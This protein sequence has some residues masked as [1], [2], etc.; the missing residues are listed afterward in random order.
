MATL[1]I[2]H[3][4]KERPRAEWLRAALQERG[5]ESLFL[6][7]HPDD[8][9]PAGSKWEQQ[10]WRQLRLSRALVVL[11]TSN[12]L[13]SPWCVAEAMM[14]R[15]RGKPVFLL[16]DAEVIDDRIVKD[17]ASGAARP[18]LPDFL[19]DT[20]F[21]SVAGLS[22]DDALQ[23]LWR[24]LD[25][26]GLTEDFPLP[27]RPYPGLEPFRETDAAVFFGRRDD[28]CQRRAEIVGIRPD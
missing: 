18:R 14:A 25:E 11:C 4:S 15:E 7:S 19:K 10:L 24:G 9:I 2:S 27:A 16:A 1:F 12:W 5:F 22:D 17:E 26:A 28:V 8:G 21:I 20:Q 23:R 3:S 13:R 6:D